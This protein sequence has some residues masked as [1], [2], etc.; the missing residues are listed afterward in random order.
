MADDTGPETEA[1]RRLAEQQA[2]AAGTPYTP[3]APQ[4]PATSPWLAPTTYGAPAAP[5]S[6]WGAPSTSSPWSTGAAGT[7]WSPW[8][9][10]TTPTATQVTTDPATAGGQLPMPTGSSRDWLPTDPN[11]PR[12]PIPP[13][14]PGTGGQWTDLPWMGPPSTGPHYD[15]NGVWIGPADMPPPGS[16]GKLFDLLMS[17]AQQPITPDTNDP[18][19]KA[20]TDA[21]N[22]SQ[23]RGATKTLQALAE[24]QGPN[25]NLAADTRSVQENAA[26]AGSNF[27]AQAMVNEIAAR[28][29]EVAQ[30]LQGATG[31]LTAEQAM[32]L[33]RELANLDSQYKFYSAGLENQ[34]FYNT[35]S[36]RENEFT[37]GQQLTREQMAQAMAQFRDSLSVQD[38]QYYDG[39]S[40]QD[41]QYFASLE[42]QRQRD[43]ADRAQRAYEYDKS[44]ERDVTLG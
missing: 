37:R 13:N 35:L 1:K 24:Q 2:A 32:T 9:D 4:P 19:L 23:Q 5:T 28:R 30:A 18:V 10:A 27:Q 31:L 15:E 22:A 42:Y 6:P 39:L 8:G 41:K 26:I 33:Q 34:Q 16:A 43:E 11:A 36:Q 44:W 7:A 21:F 40:T 29:E 20:Q 17:R 25:A 3:S 12:Q 14:Q 38:K